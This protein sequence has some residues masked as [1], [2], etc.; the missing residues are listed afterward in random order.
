MPLDSTQTDELRTLRGQKKSGEIDAAGAKRLKALK[1]LKKADDASPAAAGGSSAAAN[2]AP[3]STDDAAK[4]GEGGEGSEGSEVG[5]SAKGGKGGKSGKRG[6]R[7][8]GGEDGD[9]EAPRKAFTDGA[10]TVFIGQLPYKCSKS[11]IIEHFRKG[12][13][14][15]IKLRLLTDKKSGKFKGIAFAT[16]TEEKYFRFALRLHHS[17]L[18]GRCINVE[19]SCGGGGTGEKRKEKLRNLKGSQSHLLKRNVEELI[20]ETVAA[21]EGSIERTDFDDRIMDVLCTFPVSMVREAL[22][23]FANNPRLDDMK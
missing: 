19:R 8:K 15:D 7:G 5:E 9:G 6:K 21:S 3:S 22:D 1:K 13:A 10:L 17:M 11:Q 12:G 23:E 14:G 4:G 18:L 16:V 2:A 20:N